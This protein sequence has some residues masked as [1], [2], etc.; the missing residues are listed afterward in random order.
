MFGVWFLLSVREATAFQSGT[1]VSFQPRKIRMRP[2]LAANLICLCV[3]RTN[4]P[5]G[6]I[7]TSWSVS[8]PLSAAAWRTPFISPFHNMSCW[9]SSGCPFSKWCFPVGNKH[10]SH[11]HKCN[12]IICYSKISWQKWDY[13]SLRYCR[14]AFERCKNYLGKNMSFLLF[15]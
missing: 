14:F 4:I 15:T 7:A 12:S 8:S 1:V 13:S 6:E 3:P 9:K 2:P 5:M 11:Q 10:T